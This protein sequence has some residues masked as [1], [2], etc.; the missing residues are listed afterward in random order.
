ML[1]VSLKEMVLLLSRVSE[2]RNVTIMEVHKATKIHRN[3]LHDLAAN[4]TVLVKVEDLDK[5][6]QYMFD[7][8]LGSDSVNVTPQE[9]ASKLTANLVRWYPNDDKVLRA[10]R[11]QQEVDRECL[12]SSEEMDEKAF[13]DAFWSEYLRIHKSSKSQSQGYSS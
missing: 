8:I 3:M 6:L 4:P 11:Q 13:Y 2:R 5:L 10:V 7:R 9:L 12:G 1:R